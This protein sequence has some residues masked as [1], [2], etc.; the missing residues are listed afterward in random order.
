[1]DPCG[2]ERATKKSI[3]GKVWI[4]AFVVI[5][6]SAVIAAYYIGR[7][8]GQ[9][10][11]RLEIDSEARYRVYLVERI[12]RLESEIVNKEERRNRTKEW[13]DRADKRRLETLRAELS[14]AKLQ[15]RLADLLDP[16]PPSLVDPALYEKIWMSRS[17]KD[18]FGLMVEFYDKTGVKRHQTVYQYLEGKNLMIPSKNNM[19]DDQARVIGTDAADAVH[20]LYLRAKRRDKALDE[21][22][23]IPSKEKTSEK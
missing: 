9:H 1:M 13:E 18:V 23:P 8:I 21:G 22:I 17:I 19:S 2:S 15:P 14:A 4:L 6:L 5:A 11:A 7:H 10:N 12:A 3:A 20:E 16:P